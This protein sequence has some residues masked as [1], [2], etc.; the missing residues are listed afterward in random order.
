MT[1]RVVLQ[2]PGG[3]PVVRDVDRGEWAEPVGEADDVVGEGMW[4]LPGLVDAHSHIA[5]ARLDY[6][7]GSLE[8]ARHRAREA[9][10][11][12]VMLLLDKGW[13]DDVAIRLMEEMPPGER[14]DIEAARVLIASTGGYYPGFAREVTAEELTAAV[15]EEA[16]D[17]RGWVKL[18]G[19]WPRR[20][21][22]PQSNFTEH[23]LRI[24]V[25]TADTH[26]ARVAIH[27]MAR[28]VPSLA[29][30][31]GVD[32]IE[33]GLFLTPADLAALGARAGMWVPTVLRVEETITQLGADS[34]GGRLLKEGLRNVRRLLAEAVDAGVHVLTGTDLVGTPA[35]VAAE[36]VALGGFG[37]SPRQ[38]VD[39]VS[40]S[41]MR[42]TGRPSGFEIGAP[43]DAA[44]FPA[45]PLEGVGVLAHPAL[46]V[47]H[48]VAI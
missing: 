15:T 1:L 16:R 12:G 33:H 5:A 31:A 47:R 26:G 46:V 32:S 42:A 25:E 22:G 36:A 9:L 27:T 21:I 19:D 13:T 11:A 48:G 35:E 10:E 3:E 38:V 23:Q 8:G 4:A 17:G 20:G 44:L 34:S 40:L 6:S 28:E 30:A 43:A 7:P 41:G 45:N 29:V 14:P 39:A 2:L 18:V 24:A 37:L